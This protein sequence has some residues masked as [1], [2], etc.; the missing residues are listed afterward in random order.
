MRTRRECR[1]VGGREDERCVSVG[2]ADVFGLAAG[3]AGGGS[4]VTFE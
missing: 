1:D 2:D 4:G 3:D